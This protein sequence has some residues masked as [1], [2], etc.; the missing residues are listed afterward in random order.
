MLP[1]KPKNQKNPIFYFWGPKQNEPP[2]KK[3][4]IKNLQPKIRVLHND[5][6]NVFTQSGKHQILA[7]QEESN[8]NQ[9]QQS[10][11]RNLG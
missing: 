7:F 5:I 3:N 4:I 11:S 2:K 10:S 9:I 8:P 1:K 6:K